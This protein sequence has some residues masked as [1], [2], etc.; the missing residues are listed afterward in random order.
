MHSFVS[1]VA[2]PNLDPHMLF[3]TIDVIDLAYKAG[4]IHIGDHLGFFITLLA[5]F[6]VSHGT[7][8]TY[9]VIGTQVELYGK[10]FWAYGL[11]GG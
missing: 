7:L 1:L 3:R 4:H 2:G 8:L 9:I 6:K 11:F 10:L 5:R